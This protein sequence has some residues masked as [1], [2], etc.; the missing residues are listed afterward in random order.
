[1]RIALVSQ[2]YPPE[3][4]HGG[5]GSQTY[6]KAHGLAALGHEVHVLSSAVD[7]T[8]CEYWDGPARVTRIPG[9]RIDM[10]VYC[11]PIRWLSYSMRVAEAVWAL[12]SRTPLDVVDFP[13][14]ASEGYVHLLNQT[15]WNHVPTVVQLHGP[16]VMFAH[17]LGWPD[18]DSD[19]YRVGI[20]MEASC[21]RL[22]DAVFSSS[23]CSVQWCAEHYGL[24]PERVP[25]IH[26]GVDTT[27]F[28][29]RARSK[30]GR[31]TVIFVGRIDRAKGVDVLVEACRRLLGEYPDMHLRML[32]EGNQELID[33]LRS[34]ALDCGGRD[35]LDLPGFVPRQDLPE[36]LAAADIFAAPSRYEA[37]PG[38]VYLEAMA[39]GLPVIAC[40][41]SGVSETVVHEETGLL[42]PPGDVDALAAALRR[43]LRN[44]E[45][46]A[47]MGARAR[48][49]VLR[50][51]DS[52]VCLRRLESFYAS[53]V[54][55]RRT[56]SKGGRR[57]SP[58]PSYATDTT[59]PCS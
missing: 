12:H 17:A 14:W 34:A 23:R 20:A 26:A 42:V 22:A 4:A 29:P 47:V 32:G 2:E 43:L 38:F 13:D 41:G 25:I 27:L 55:Q 15:E 35:L 54:R 53:V 8:G 21:L 5:I 1:M 45:E 57:L 58:N 46:R 33:D 56:S 9:F 36:Q 52:R 30:R 11:E 39:C 31:P 37:G 59:G 51:A 18:V 10:P 3:T 6:A 7:N 16:L 49:H 40:A 44:P 19:F 28:G 48:Q 24:D 50:T